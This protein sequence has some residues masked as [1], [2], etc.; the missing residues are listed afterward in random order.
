M[1]IL[2]NMDIV[3]MT[4][5]LMHIHNFHGHIVLLD[6]GEGPTQGLD[7]TTIT[8]EAKYPINFTRPGRGFVLHLHYNASNSFLFVDTVK[9]CQFKATDS[10]TRSY[11][12]CLG[13]ISKDFIINHMDM[14]INGYVDVFS[15]D[16]KITGTSHNLDI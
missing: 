14:W 16:Y 13:Y 1:L 5:D 3:V 2:V 8:A 15:V 12:V 9:M 10:E 4:F 6:F 7:D 11:P